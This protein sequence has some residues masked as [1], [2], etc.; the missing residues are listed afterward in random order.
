MWCKYLYLVIIIVLLFPITI[1]W[2]IFFNVHVFCE[3]IPEN[4]PT[5]FYFVL[6]GAVIYGVFFILMT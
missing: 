6:F 3:I 1:T 4:D 5:R 2:Q